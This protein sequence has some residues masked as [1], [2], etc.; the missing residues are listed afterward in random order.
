MFLVS[1]MAVETGKPPKNIIPTSN[2]A[3]EAS[4]ATGKTA[5]ANLPYNMQPA[6]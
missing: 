1:V 4:N 6:S 3:H 5:T 2:L